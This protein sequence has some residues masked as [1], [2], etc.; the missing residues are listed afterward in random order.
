[1]TKIN[2]Q[3]QRGKPAADRFAE[4]V[5]AAE[6][7]CHEWQS[8]IGSAGYGIFWAS[9]V[10]RSVMA[11]RFAWELA[12]GAEPPADRVIMHSCDNRRC[13]NPAHLLPGSNL[14]NMRDAAMKGR[15]ARGTRNGGGAKL[16]DDKVREILR[17]DESGAALGRRFGVHRSIVNGIRRREG[18]RHVK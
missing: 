15:I 8:A 16:T 6:S 4:K 14:E 7:G 9:A 2:T 18:W 3:G 5:R 11:H 1:M 13:V 10:R 17:S 12:H